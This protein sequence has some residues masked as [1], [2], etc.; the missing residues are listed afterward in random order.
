MCSKEMVRSW[1][2]RSG[3]P[4]EATRRVRNRIAGC[5]LVARLETRTRQRAPIT[6]M[7]IHI[8]VRRMHRP[9]HLGHSQRVRQVIPPSVLR[10]EQ[11]LGAAFYPGARLT[12]MASQ[13][14]TRPSLPQPRRVAPSLPPRLT[15]PDPG[16]PKPPAPS[17]AKPTPIETP[18]SSPATPKPVPKSKIA[19]PSGGNGRFRIRG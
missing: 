7:W 15:Q 16:Q 5:R 12:R 14:R 11:H 2:E 1:G 3:D 9:V 8:G 17:L 10:P 6:R 4:M 13:K 19:I 18:S